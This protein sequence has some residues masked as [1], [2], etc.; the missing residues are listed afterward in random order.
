MLKPVAYFAI[1]LFAG[2]IVSE[3][4]KD[5]KPIE[6]IVI[7]STGFASFINSATVSPANRPMAKYP[8]AFSICVV[9]YSC[10]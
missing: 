10:E 2:L 9:F 7:F 5:A 4:M 3:L 1:G 8:I 6:K